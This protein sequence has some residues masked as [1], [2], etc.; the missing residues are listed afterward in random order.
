[1]RIETS[2]RSLW[3][4]SKSSSTTA[5]AR[6]FERARRAEQP[7]V[8]GRARAPPRASAARLPTSSPRVSASAPSGAGS[9][10]DAL[11]VP[12][13]ALPGAPLEGVRARGCAPPT[14][15]RRVRGP[16]ARRRC[17][18]ARCRAEGSPATS[19]PASFTEPRAGARCRSPI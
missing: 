14:C 11:L 5:G 15:P 13:C 10:E 19:S 1:M 2:P 4:D 12:R 18:A 8:A 3:N 9:G 17:R 6:P 16:A 7:R